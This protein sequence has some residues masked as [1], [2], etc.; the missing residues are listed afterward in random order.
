MDRKTTKEMAYGICR[1][2]TGHGSDKERSRELPA[3]AEMKE[4]HP[5]MF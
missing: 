1:G 4:S 3:I 2:S 5:S